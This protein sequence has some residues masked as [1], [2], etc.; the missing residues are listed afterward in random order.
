M[1]SLSRQTLLSFPFLLHFSGIAVLYL[2]LALLDLDHESGDRTCLHLCHH[3]LKSN[4]HW[5]ELPVQLCSP[6]LFLTSEL[7]YASVV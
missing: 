1:S 7:L 6:L 5:I 2:G 3:I 4:S